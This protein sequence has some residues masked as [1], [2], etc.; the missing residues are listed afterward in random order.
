MEISMEQNSIQKD[1]RILTE[2][3]IS[4]V[5]GGKVE[6]F[7]GFLFTPTGFHLGTFTETPSGNVHF[8]EF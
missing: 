2:E 6:R 8:K 4:N 7:T 5:S 1:L 3:E